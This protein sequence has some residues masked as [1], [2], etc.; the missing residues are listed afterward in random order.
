MNVFSTEVNLFIFHLISGEEVKSDIYHF[1]YES[2]KVMQNIRIGVEV[3]HEEKGVVQC[4]D[5]N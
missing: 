5:C 1:S 3:I 4:Q 2:R